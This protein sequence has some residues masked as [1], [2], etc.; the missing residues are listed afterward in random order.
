MPYSPPSKC[1]V[2][3]N[4][5]TITTMTCENCSSQINGSFTPCKYCS[6]ND[7]HRLFLETFLKCRGNIKEVERS[8]SLSYPTVKSLLDDLLFYLFGTREEESPAADYTAA[9]IL[10]KLERKEIS[11]ARA[12]ELLAALKSKK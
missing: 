1:P 9:D 10:D 6:L 2:C 11:A 12:S 7:K 5:L 4:A 3:G 8:L